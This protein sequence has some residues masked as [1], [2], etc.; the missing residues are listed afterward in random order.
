MLVGTLI[1]VKAA[2]VHKGYLEGLC[3]N[4]NGNTDDD[5]TDN[6][7]DFVLNE[8]TENVYDELPL[9]DPCQVS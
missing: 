3:S 5:F 6:F 4:Y 9:Y 7:A 8:C 2:P 1:R